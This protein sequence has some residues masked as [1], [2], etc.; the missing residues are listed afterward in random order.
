VKKDDLSKV[1]AYS[2]VLSRML[3]HRFNQSVGLWANVRTSGAMFV[4]GRDIV[5][6]IGVAGWLHVQPSST[7]CLTVSL[8]R[9]MS[10]Q[11]VRFL[12]LVV[13]RFCRTSCHNE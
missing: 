6:V 1:S 3:L 5:G 12:L 7:L 9:L 4:A 2:G 8:G 10:R 13:K 11:V